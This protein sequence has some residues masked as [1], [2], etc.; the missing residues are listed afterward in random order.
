MD[1][2]NIVEIKNR[3]DAMIQRLNTNNYSYNGVILKETDI[4]ILT[5]LFDNMFE[6]FE[7]IIEA[8][9]DL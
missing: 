9:Y 8:K 2:Y 4:L 3:Y 1:D 6:T 7:E 5:T